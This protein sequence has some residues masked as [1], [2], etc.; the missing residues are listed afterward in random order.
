MYSKF[1]GIGDDDDR[2]KPAAPTPTRES[3]LDELKQMQKGET[4]S[5][6][7]LMEKLKALPPSMKD[8]LASK[9]GPLAQGIESG[10]QQQN[11]SQQPGAALKDSAPDASFAKALSSTTGK[12]AF[13]QSP[14]IEKAEEVRN[15]KERRGMINQRC[16]VEGLTSKPELNGRLGTVTDWFPSKGRFAVKLEAVTAPLLLKPHNVQLPEKAMQQAFGGRD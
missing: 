10:R 2:P 1:D 12:S 7:E 8:Q 14:A 13:G 3:F 15:E 11:T 4:P 6:K 5:V 9:L 16:I